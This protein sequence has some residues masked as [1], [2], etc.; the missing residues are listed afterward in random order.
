MGGTV[1]RTTFEALDQKV[2]KAGLVAICSKDESKCTDVMVSNNI[3]AGGIYA[4]FVVPGHDCGDSANSKFKGNVAH[5]IGGPKMGHGALIYPENG[6]AKH[7]LCFEGS[8]FSAYKCYY[9]GAY[10]YYDTQNV[11]LSHMTMIDNRNGFG[12]AMKNGPI[13]T[14]RDYAPG[15]I[16]LNDNKIYGECEASDCPADG[17]FCKP[18]EKYGMIITGATF[19]GKDLHVE[20]MS[21]L[22]IPKLK[23]LSTWGTIQKMYRNEFI[24]FEAKTSE[25]LRQSAI[26]I[27]EWQSDYVPIMEF[28]ETTFTDVKDGAMA[29]IYDP[30]E[31]WANLDDCG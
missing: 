31:K 27:N 21:P 15:T 28:F 8:Y 18:V 24:G 7:N 16:Q 25:G 20:D 14:A 5:S 10:S 9:Q 19:N 13:F 1:E 23:S 12:A 30:P 4:G 22:P 2:D 29:Y 6:N 11:I 17:S 26:Q 3:A